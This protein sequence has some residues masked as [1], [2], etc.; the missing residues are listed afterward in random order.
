[1]TCYSLF[2]SRRAKVNLNP[3]K[4]HKFVPDTEGLIL[5]HEIIKQYQCGFAPSIMR[6]RVLP[7]QKVF[8]NPSLPM[9][10]IGFKWRQTLISVI[11]CDD[12]NGRPIF[13]PREHIVVRAPV[14]AYLGG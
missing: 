7:H 2:V 3:W 9:R 14:D 8:S 4:N 1:M 11:L 6:M 12:M 13:H 10:I 5:V